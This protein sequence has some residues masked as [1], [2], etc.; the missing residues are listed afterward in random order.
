VP[1]HVLTAAGADVTDHFMAA[2]LQ[3]YA[4]D[5]ANTAGDAT[6]NIPAIPGAGGYTVPADSTC[7]SRKYVVAGT[8]PDTYTAPSSNGTGRSAYKDVTNLA[9]GCIDIA[10][11]SSGPAVGDPA[12][13]QFY[14]YAKDAV[15]WAAFN[16]GHAPAGLTKAQIQGIYNCTYTDWSQVGGT[17]GHIQRYFT[18]AGSGTGT[19][20]VNN[21]LNGSDP[22]TVSGPGCPAVIPAQQS[23]GNLIASG[24]KP[25]AIMPYSA[26]DW[27]AQANGVVANS[28][29][30][31]T[32]R[33]IVVSGTPL[34]PVGRPKLGKYAPDAAVIGGGLFPGV[35]TIYNVVDTDAIAY[36]AARNAV[37]FDANNPA[38]GVKSPLCSGHLANLLKTYGFTPLTADGNGV[39]CTLVTP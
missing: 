23:H 24:D 4:T 12:A 38:S 2:A 21:I 19:F 22:T 26:G 39:T 11:A 10:R 14:G 15:T 6:A 8:P 3:A 16:G 25:F 27:I 37:G 33:P 9:N 35:R 28:R 17:A 31:A 30:S 1:T 36:T 34:N 13:F 32:L 20:F 5:A 18:Q 7:E 29:S